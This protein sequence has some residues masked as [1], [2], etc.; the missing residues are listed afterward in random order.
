[1]SV[2]VPSLRLRPAALCD[3]A[4]VQRLAQAIWREHYRSI[5]SPAQI[6]YMLG[7]GYSDAAL[8]PFV[9]EPARGLALAEEDGEAVGFAAWYP[10]DEPAT[11][12]LDK[13]YVLPQRH[14][15]GIG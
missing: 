7:R 11:L 3:V 5:L 8:A 4:T 2:I 13:L 14:G 12:K 10:A 15:R 1:M 6:E 9:T